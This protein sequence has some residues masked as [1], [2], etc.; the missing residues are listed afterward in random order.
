MLCAVSLIR[1]T[2]PPF[3][4]DAINSERYTGPILTPS[5]KNL[6]DDTDYLLI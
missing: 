2:E 5:F 6:S 4:S 1:I 3:I